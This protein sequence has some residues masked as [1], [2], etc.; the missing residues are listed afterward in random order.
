MTTP[1]DDVCAALVPKCEY[2]EEIGEAVNMLALG[3]NALKG[4]GVM[5]MPETLGGDEQLNMVHR[6][7]VA[8]IFRFFGEALS[9][10]ASLAN[11]AADR[12]ELAES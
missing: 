10:P 1:N 5:M 8:A 6:S 12:L 7:E 11:D 2:V 3:A 4:I 9:K